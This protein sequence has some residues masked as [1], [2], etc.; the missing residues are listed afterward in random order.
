MSNSDSGRVLEILLLQMTS[1]DRERLL[2]AWERHAQGDPDSLPALYAMADRFSLIAH[3]AILERQENL[4]ADFEKSVT[5][6][7]VSSEQRNAKGSRIWLVGTLCCVVAGATGAAL[8]RQFPFLPSSA[9]D[10]GNAL[11]QQIRAAGGDLLHRVSRRDGKLVHVLELRCPAR[12]PEAYLTPEHHGVI[13][14]E[15]QPSPG[16]R[17]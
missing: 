2:V 1:E 14:F 17:K 16:I 4:L 11:V 10:D 6:I 5:N 15:H 9:G 7:R 12:P 3:A 13:V 8:A